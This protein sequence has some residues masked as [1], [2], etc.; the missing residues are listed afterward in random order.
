MVEIRRRFVI[1]LKCCYSHLHHEGH[2]DAE[3][4]AIL[5]DGAN[6][7][8]D[9]TDHE[10]ERQVTILKIL[11]S[12]QPANLTPQAASF[13]LELQHAHVRSLPCLNA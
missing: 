12:I 7:Q 5:V 8:I 13:V 1:A 9:D 11:A 6:R 10:A 4:V 3:S 2:C